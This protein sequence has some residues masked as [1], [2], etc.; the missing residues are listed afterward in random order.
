[1][2]RK[3]GR[4]IEARPRT[5]HRVL[6]EERDGE[7]SIDIGENGILFSTGCRVWETRDNETGKALR[8]T[9]EMA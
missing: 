6:I 5:T 3:G 7:G 9:V 8:V 2:K 4:W 1:M